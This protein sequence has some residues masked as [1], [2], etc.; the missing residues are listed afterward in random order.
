MFSR[1]GGATQI[2]YFWFLLEGSAL[3]PSDGR[4]FPTA[5]PG[6]SCRWSL[7]VVVVDDLSV[8]LHSQENCAVRHQI[9]P[10]ILQTRL[11]PTQTGQ[12]SSCVQTCSDSAP[13]KPRQ[14]HKKVKN[15]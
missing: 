13:E 6:A 11:E 9:I 7:L 1:R 3:G 12:M 8:A 4:G 15:V 14:M 5:H 10:A 2:L